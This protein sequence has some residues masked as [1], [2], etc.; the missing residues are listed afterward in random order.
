MLKTIQIREATEKDISNI[1]DFQLKMALETEN[2]TL[3]IATLSQ[4]VQ[5]LLKDSTK[6]RYYVAEEDEEVMGCLMT[7]Y[8]WSD[9]RCGNV[10]WIQSVYIVAAHRGKGVYKKMYEHIQQTVMNDP[11]YRGI[12]LYVDKTNQQAQRVYAK[13][14]MNGEHYQVYEWMKVDK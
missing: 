8:E 1:I 3:D 5:K 13:L 12:R 10:L 2:I 14:G 6:G 4:G 11:D 9:W 7:T